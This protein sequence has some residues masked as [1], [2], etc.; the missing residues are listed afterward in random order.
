[1]HTGRAYVWG[2]R[3][4]DAVGLHDLQLRHVET[5]AGL[6]CER[7]AVTEHTSQEDV[8]DLVK[9][10]AVCDVALLSPL[11]EVVV[12]GFTGLGRRCV[13][14]MLDAVAHRV[15]GEVVEDL[16]EQPAVAFSPATL[17]DH[18][19]SVKRGQV[20]TEVTRLG[21]VLP[22]TEASQPRALPATSGGFGLGGSL[23]GL[24][25]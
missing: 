25:G 10:E 20:A 14:L 24:D 6:D 3:V 9:R 19:Q 17:T 23:A 13:G 21:A 4:A 12:I 16:I 22:E 5:V 11:G 1:M 8:L 7:V 15:E 18:R 2:Q